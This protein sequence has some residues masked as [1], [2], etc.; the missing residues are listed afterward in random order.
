[1]TI[2]DV[3]A[4]SPTDRYRL[5]EAIWECVG[6]SGE[7]AMRH[8]LKYPELD[9]HPDAIGGDPDAGLTWAMVKTRAMPNA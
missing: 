4:L 9:V 6:V 1:M 3:L 7:A 5:V 8:V 2:R